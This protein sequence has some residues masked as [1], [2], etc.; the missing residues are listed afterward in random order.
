M[1]DQKAFITTSNGVFRI[2][3]DS[4]S[5]QKVLD[6]RKGFWPIRR[7]GKGFFGID[8][9]PGSRKIIVASRERLGTR[10]K[11]KPTTDLRLYAIDPQTLQSSVIA[12]IRDV[13]DVHQIAISGD[14]VFLTDC[15]LNRVQ[16]YDLNKSEIVAIINIGHVRDDINHV[17]AL[18]IDEE[19]LM[20]GLNNR[21][22]RPAE[23]V[24]I[25]LGKCLNPQPLNSMEIGKSTIL[26]GIMHTHDL[27]PADG[28]LM[29]CSSFEGNVYDALTGRKLFHVHDWT[30]GLAIGKEEIWIGSSAL[31]DRKRRH[32]EDLDGEVHL[33]T[34]R[35]PWE[36]I[37]TYQLRSAG[38][39]NDI[40]L[41]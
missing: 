10:R 33:F 15:G 20:I 4:G 19:H 14:V 2:D 7:G 31:A 11:T 32:R 18:Y 27:E 26:D 39:V 13:H 5:T 21:G 16:A 25:P 29:V 12:D 22:V 3:P 36:L 41:V 38:Q 34:P 8:F 1:S 17:N 28:R 35:P 37:R 23:I 9:H 40:I 30:R 6:R 24:R